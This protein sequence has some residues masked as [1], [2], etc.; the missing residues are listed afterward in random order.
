MSDVLGIHQIMLPEDNR[1][2][3]VD[4]KYRAHSELLSSQR[5]FARP[6]QTK[7]VG[8]VYPCHTRSSQGGCAG[9]LQT[10]RPETLDLGTHRQKETT[11]PRVHLS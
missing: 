5:P 7:H 6:Q 9:V 4:Q 11:V 3:G 2:A 10:V 1:T 8:A